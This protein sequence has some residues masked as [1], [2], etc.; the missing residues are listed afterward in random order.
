MSLYSNES[1]RQIPLESWK[2]DALD[3]FEEKM[4]NQYRPFPCIPATIGHQLNRFRYAFISK[5]D[6]KSSVV[7]LAEILKEY[8]E[9]YRKIGAYTSLIIFYEPTQEQYSLEQYEQIFWTQLNQVC[10]M[11]VVK[12]PSHIPTNPHDPLWEFCFHGEQ[13]FVYCATPSHENRLSRYFPYFLIAVTPRSV[14]ENFY[15]STSQSLKIKSKIRERLVEYDT[16][17][18]HPD[19]NSYGQNDN[20]EWK[21]YFLHDDDT[22]LSKCPFH[23][24]LKD[25]RE[26]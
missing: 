13:L 24:Y 21:Q 9:S 10:E 25:N 17:S 12:W 8:A 22:T 14:L 5:L 7:E 1:I 6:S 4:T 16:I 20:F 18:I 19:L 15:S 11:D 26:E 2:K 23:K 3:K